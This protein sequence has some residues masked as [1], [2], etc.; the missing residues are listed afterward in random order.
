MGGDGREGSIRDMHY[1]SSTIEKKKYLAIL[2]VKNN[3]LKRTYSMKQFL[4][5]DQQDLKGSPTRILYTNDDDDVKS[6][7]SEQRREFY[8]WEQF[9]CLGEDQ[10]AFTY[11]AEK[12]LGIIDCEEICK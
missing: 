9:K 2:Y 3:L 12:N 6:S 11:G 7:K 8:W 10:F 4:F 1:H 5:T